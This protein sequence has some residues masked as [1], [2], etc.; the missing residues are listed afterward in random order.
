MEVQSQDEFRAASIPSYIPGS[1]TSIYYKKKHFSIITRDLLNRTDRPKLLKDRLMLEL[2]ALRIEKHNCFFEAFD[3]K[4]QQYIE[5]G[6]ND[7]NSKEFVETNNPKKFEKYKELFAVLTLSELEA[8]FVVC[9]VPFLLSILVFCLE[10]LPTLKNLIVFLF[11]FKKYF[12]VK[13]LEQKKHCELMKIKFAHWQT[14][15]RRIK[16]EDAAQ[17]QVCMS[18]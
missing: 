14:L 15:I 3:R 6:L 8:G 7:Y 16:Q 2:K 12:E 9:I 13:E 4:L 1:K 11:V 17:V 10:W 18:C 5:G